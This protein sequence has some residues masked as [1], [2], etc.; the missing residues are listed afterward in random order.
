M[1]KSEKQLKEMAMLK[2]VNMNRLKELQCRR[3]ELE[4]ERC[5]IQYD[6]ERINGEIQ[7][8]ECK[9]NESSIAIAKAK[10]K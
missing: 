5:K 10:K 1:K 9:I 6:L 2:D 7:Q 8:C 4:K 3:M